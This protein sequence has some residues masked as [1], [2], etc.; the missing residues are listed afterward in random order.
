M[1][2]K[3]GTE[4]QIFDMNHANDPEWR[5]NLPDIKLSGVGQD[6]INLNKNFDPKKMH[7]A[8]L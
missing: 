5:E 3:A 2:K 8:A 7:L 1:Q 6:Q 4:I